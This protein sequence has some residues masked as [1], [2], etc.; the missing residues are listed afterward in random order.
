MHS[1]RHLLDARLL[2]VVE[3]AQCTPV[4]R[5]LKAG[6]TVTDANGYEHTVIG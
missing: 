3:G 5:P 6:S 2:Q 1:H 4:W